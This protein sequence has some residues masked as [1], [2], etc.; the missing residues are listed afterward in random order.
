M[1]SYSQIG[2]ILL[3]GV[4]LILF[5]GCGRE[6][7]TQTTEKDLT[8]IRERIELI[9]EALGM[10]R[11]GE[12]PE[13]NQ[14]SQSPLK[15]KSSP[16]F[17]PAKQE[18]SLSVI[19]EWPADSEGWYTIATFLDDDVVEIS[20]KVRYKDQEGNI[21]TWDS[22]EE[23]DHA[24]AN[25]RL[26][27]DLNI[28]E[29]LKVRTVYTSGKISEYYN[30]NQGFLYQGR[31][32]AFCVTQVGTVSIPQEGEE[33]VVSYELKWVQW[34]SEF[35]ETERQVILGGSHERTFKTSDNW[36]GLIKREWTGKLEVASLQGYI[37]DENGKKVATLVRDEE[38]YVCYV[39]VD[40]PKQERY[41]MTW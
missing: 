30:I 22:E 35:R 13:E 7:P 41:R 5:S 21:L 29:E 15:L 1:R 26:A 8:A 12:S 24:F 16:A 19:T 20:M 2:L 27:H 31:Y 34:L 6:T 11:R 3:S 37:N 28:I 38:Y 36:T 17:S 18:A 9:A 4:V 39:L 40:D 33:F 10:P 25:G 32:P 14:N 23:Y